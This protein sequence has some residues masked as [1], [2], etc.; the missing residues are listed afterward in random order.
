MALLTLLGAPA[1][2]EG[3]VAVGCGGL[4][5]APLAGC[6]C[7]GTGLQP[8]LSCTWLPSRKVL[9]FFFLSFP[10]DEENIW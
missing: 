1:L 8:G 3:R 4:C 10:K 5:N 9:R 2:K 7:H 6:S